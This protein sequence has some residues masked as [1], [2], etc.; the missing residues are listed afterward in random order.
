MSSQSFQQANEQRMA[1]ALQ[2]IEKLQAK[3]T[4]VEAARTE[5]IA[6]VGIG[7][8]FPGNANS[9][10]DFWQVL[11]N[12]T[13]AIGQ[14]P[15]DRWDADVFY[16]ADPD[17]PGKIVTQN[18]G[19]IDQ[20]QDFDAAFFGI[21]PREAVSMD[22][23]QRLL[24][25]V[26][27][28]AMEHGGMV[29]EQWASRPVGIFMGIS[30]HDYSQ[31]LSRRDQ[32]EI[33]AYLAT[34]NAHSVAAGR[35]SYSL[36]FTGPSL[37]VDTACSSSLVAVHLAC[38]SL[39]HQECEVALAGGVNRI[40]APEFSINFSKAHMLAPDGR[41]K[42]FDA[43]ANGF[44]RGEGC[45]VIVLKRLSDAMAHNDNILAVV[46]GSAVNQDGRSSGLTVPNGPSQQS[47]IC[48][49]LASAGVKPEDIRY[50]EAHGTGTALGDPI[51]VGALGAVFGQSHSRQNPLQIGSVKTNIGHLEAA[52]GIA[53]LIKVVLAMQHG[54]L[55][56]HLH[57]QQPSP[58]IDWQGIPVQVTAKAMAWDS[59]EKTRL[60]G[61]SSFGFSGTNAHVVVGSVEQP[62]TAKPDGFGPYL[63]ML[64]AKDDTAL[65]ELA[66]LYGER[67]NQPGTELRDIC[68]S[69]WALRSHH[70]HRLAIVAKSLKDAQTQL[71]GQLSHAIT[72][73]TKQRP[74]KIAFLF[75]GQGAQ[76]INMGRQL[77]KTEPVFRQTIDHCAQILKADN[78]DLLELLY[79]ST[80]VSVERSKVSIHNTA[81]TQPA[82]FA[83]AYALTE[84]W[85]SWGITPSGVLGHSISE[86][87]AACTAGVMDWEI[88]LRLI[89]VRGRLMQALPEGG[90]MAAVMASPEQIEPYL[91]AGVAI[92]AYNSPT[93]TVLSGSQ[94]ALEKVLA[95]LEKQHIQT[96]PLRVSHGFHSP[97]MAPVLKDFEAIAHSV[98]YQLPQLDMVS[99]VTGQT[100]TQEITQ[101]DYWVRHIRQPVKFSQAMESLAAEN[102]DILIEIGPKPTLITLGQQ[103][104]PDGSGHWLPSL[105]L[106]Q[107]GQSSERH[108]MLMGLGHLYVAGAPIQWPGEAG[109]RVSLPTYPFQRQRYWIDVQPV[110]RRSSQHPLLGERLNLARSE[111]V[112]FENEIGAISVPFLA[113]HQVFGATVLPA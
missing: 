48:Q 16:D 87:A 90:G 51:E 56:A 91:E 43:S 94:T 2:A 74:P 5:P 25:E 78:I 17:A 32:S 20:L 36:G 112:F 26:S 40:L 67:I 84:L 83:I 45:G 82:L 3:L 59:Q 107:D 42:T 79:P 111:S 86:Y 80:D 73:K 22:P 71:T 21:S 109:Q 92:A 88:G 63:L 7:C 105:H 72:G 76:H 49:A 106:K 31:H 53:G 66:D 97:L 103:C 100:I 99:T 35:L 110:R 15:N 64:S 18:G 52:A 46:R 30:S 19:F 85:K 108:T 81:N 37:V 95:N 50:I 1:R 93:N 34:G 68:W 4:A 98:P 61:I 9:P 28:E 77:Y 33:D 11:T 70:P 104:L 23:Q 57:F 113:E 89:A 55:P 8:R 10:E 60:A 69:A 44:A 58:H 14:V 13:D 39:R 38:Q 101:P 47:V 102:Y 12:E 24:L 27:W 54:T 6:I 62:Q 29:P 65:R 96:K 41:C 75:T